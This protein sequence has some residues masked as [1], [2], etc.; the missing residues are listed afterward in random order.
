MLS[1]ST[2]NTVD[3]RI[4]PQTKCRPGKRRPVVSQLVMK[5]GIQMGD[6]FIRAEDVAKEL[7]IS[8]AYAYKTLCHILI[9]TIQ[10]F[11]MTGAEQGTVHLK[12]QAGLLVIAVMVASAKVL[13]LEAHILHNGF[14]IIGA[15]CIRMR[16][17]SAG[18]CPPSVV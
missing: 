16:S 11:L 9:I 8:K 3:T 10:S 15:C 2:K 17:P 12:I 6:K 1:V 4:I 5:E 7:D 18:Y 13:R 14:Y